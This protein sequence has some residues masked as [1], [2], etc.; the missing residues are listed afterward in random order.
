MRLRVR[1]LI[2]AL[3]LLWP[4]LVKAME[5]VDA[6]L[7]AS[8]LLARYLDV[9][10]TKDALKRGAVETNGLYGGDRPS[11]GTIDRGGALMGAATAALGTLAPTNFSRPALAG[12]TGLEL[13]V[14][15]QNQAASA[16]GK[17][18]GFGETVAMPLLVGA[19]LATMT[20]LLNNDFNTN[21]GVDSD[22]KVTLSVTKKF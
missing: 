14:A 4:I 7:L 12:L 8:A 15:Q 6:G 13:A 3:W 19:G 22:R 1:L 9:Q 5:P 21:V 16:N 20:A 17:R 10:T 2:L 11:A 18:R